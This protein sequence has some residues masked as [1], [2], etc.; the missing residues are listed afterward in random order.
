MRLH[1]HIIGA[2]AIVALAGCGTEGNQVR[3]T[4]PESNLALDEIARAS[5][6]CDHLL[7]VLA[8]AQGDPELADA[9]RPNIDLTGDLHFHMV[10]VNESLEKVEMISAMAI[11][12]GWARLSEWDRLSQAT[13]DP[14]LHTLRIA[15]LGKLNDTLVSLSAIGAQFYANVKT[16]KSLEALAIAEY[17]RGLHQD[18]IDSTSSKMSMLIVDEQQ[19]LKSIA[20]LASTIISLKEIVTTPNMWIA[21]N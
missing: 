9:F 19:L 12:C 14:G 8:S 6:E 3:S 17:D 20:D 5:R 4:F 21:S 10:M 13:S 16:F 18:G 7:T 2:L 15:R 11:T 1:S